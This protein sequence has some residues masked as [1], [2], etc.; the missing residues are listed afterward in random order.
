MIS[1]EG[2]GSFVSSAAGAT[3]VSDANPAGIP[4]GAS[5]LLLSWGFEPETAGTT[6]T[7]FEGSDSILSELNTRVEKQNTIQ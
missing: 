1:M 5:L 6:S 4:S 7:S 3:D 2:S